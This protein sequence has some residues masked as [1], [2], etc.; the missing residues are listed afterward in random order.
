MKSNNQ[1]LRPTVFFTIVF[2][3]LFLLVCKSQ[4]LDSSD[5]LFHLSFED[6]IDAE[7]SRGAGRPFN[8][9]QDLQRRLVDGVSGKGYLFGGKGCTLEYSTGLNRSGTSEEIY[10]PRANLFPDSGTISFWLKPLLNTHDQHHDFVRFGGNA[11]Y[12]DL[13][14]VWYFSYAGK[15]QQVYN[16]VLP[17]GEWMHINGGAKL[18]HLA[19]G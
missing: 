9:P 3:V 16:T 5:L 7:F 18:Y 10:G 2:F 4:A 17:L 12:R 11:V 1:R 15:R 19:G 8:E 13:Y 6:G 14:N